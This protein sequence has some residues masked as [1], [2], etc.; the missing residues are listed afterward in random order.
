MGFIDDIKSCFSSEELPTV[1]LFR[2]VL[3]GEGALYVE[4]VK[5]IVRYTEEEIVLGLKRGGLAICG[6]DLY[7]KKYCEGDVVICGKIKAV[8]RI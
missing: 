6:S 4:N 8:Q 5:Q 7:V 1:P 3:F 2:A